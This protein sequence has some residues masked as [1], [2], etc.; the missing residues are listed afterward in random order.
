MKPAQQP[1]ETSRRAIPRDSILRDRG[2]LGLLALGFVLRVLMQFPLYK[3]PADA[4]ALGSPATTLDVLAGNHPVFYSGVRLGAL[5]AYLQA[6]FVAALGPSRAAVTFLPILMGLLTLVLYAVFVGGCLER[7]LA[8]TALLFLALPPPNVVIWTS[9]PNG[10]PTTLALGLVVLLLARAYVSDGRLVVAAGLGFAAG[11][12]FWNTPQSVSCI[13]VAGLWVLLGRRRDTLR[14]GTLVTVL[15]ATAIGLSPWLAFNATHSFASL[16]EGYGL[17]HASSASAALDNAANLVRVQFRQL[18][19]GCDWDTARS[20]GASAPF[21]GPV[22]VLYAI[23][24]L[25]LVPEAIAFFRRRDPGSAARTSS[26]LALAGVALLSIVLFVASRAGEL[27]GVTSVRYLLLGYF[28][29][30]VALAGGASALRRLWP[31]LAY[32]PLLL[33]ALFNLATYDLPWSSRRGAWREGVRTDDRLLALLDQR[34]ITTIVGGYWSIYSFNYLSGGR[35]HAVPVQADWDLRRQA[36]RLP[37]Q[38][39]RLAVVDHDS[40]NVTAWTTG[41]RLPGARVAV[42]SYT[43]FFPDRNAELESSPRELVARLQAAFEKSS[44]AGH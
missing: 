36:E 11:L 43:V 32:A 2:V 38:G 14:P 29:V 26:C 23:L 31:P 5:E 42:D 44:S 12:A 33:I 27:R 18:L 20:H 13:G 22:L 3:Y 10:Y 35:I 4:D 25:S 19:V 30:P 15:V 39:G 28:F 40:D 7:P 17:Q 8:R 41:A 37:D 6:P 9:L 34:E 21:A 1:T 16:H 24:F